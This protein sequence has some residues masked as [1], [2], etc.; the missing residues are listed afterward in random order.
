MKPQKFLALTAAALLAAL[1][2]TACATD[3]SPVASPT[4][5]STPTSDVT[6]PAAGQRGEDPLA[7]FEAAATASCNKAMAEGVVEAIAKGETPTET[8]WW[9]MMVPKDQAINDFSAAR[10]GK[11]ED[12]AE[13][14]YETYEFDTCY[15]ST[16]FALAKEAGV[17]ITKVMSVSYDQAADLYVVRE[18]QNAGNVQTSQFVL[19]AAGLITKVQYPDLGAIAFERTVRYGALT[20]QEQGWFKRAVESANG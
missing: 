1:G 14:I 12:L 3:S 18:A 20:E 9:L 7:E 10:Y 15:M 8:E 2:L 4:A 13:V 19:D 16:Q 5:S 17:D 6:P 11:A